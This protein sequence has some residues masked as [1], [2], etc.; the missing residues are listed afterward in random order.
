MHCVL[1]YLLLI[2]NFGNGVA[3][4]QKSHDLHTIIGRNVSETR[5]QSFEV[6]FPDSAYNRLLYFSKACGMSSCITCD[7]IK[8]DKSLYE[9]G[10]PDHIEFC[11]NEE[12][13]PTI[14][15]TRIALVLQ[16]EKGELGTGYV[17]VDHD[18]EV[19]TMVFRSSTTSQDWR[20]NMMALPIDYSPVCEY[21]YRK[22]ID[23]GEIRECVDCKMHRG[24]HKFTETL[25]KSFLRKIEGI[26]EAYPEFQVVSAGHSLGAALAVI[27][28]IELRLR[29]YTP[30]VLAYAPPRIFNNNMKE[31]VDELF[32]SS[33]IH[34]RILEE[35]EVVFDHGYFR[36]VHKQ[37]YVP[38]LPPF[39]HIAGLEI[40][41]NKGYLPH[42]SSDLEYLGPN[43]ELLSKLETK[44]M[45]NREYFEK[46]VH[47]NQHREYFIN[48]GGCSGF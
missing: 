30:L 13:N 33:T 5:S 34:E 8:R 27:A 37:D 17:M 46:M 31:W 7:G 38:S 10:C 43:E 22:M 21:E 35:G 20:S 4:Q 25:G 16:A 40:F 24:F 29:G 15:Y 19:I 2:L 1:I 6:Y 44:T 45:F 47:T 28:G 14:R 11:H 18:R 39:Y 42:L 26:L 23:E 9:G 3:A 36:V 48:L 12:I 41:I 32:D